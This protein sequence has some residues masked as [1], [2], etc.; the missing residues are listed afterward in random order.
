ME[1]VVAG[2]YQFQ[3]QQRRL[4]QYKTLGPRRLGQG[5]EGR[6]AIRAV[7]PIE[8]LKRHAPL[9]VNHLQRLLCIGL[10]EETTAQNLMPVDSRLPGLVETRDIQAVHIDAH[11]VDVVARPFAVQRLEQHALLHRRQRIQIFHLGEGQ[12]QRIQ[13]ALRQ[14]RQREVR[15]RDTLVGGGAAML[16]QR[17]E[18]HRVVIRQLLH[19]RLR[20]HCLAETPVQLQFA[21]VD[22]AVDFQPV[23]Q[24]CVKALLGTTGVTGRREQAFLFAALETAVKLPQVVERDT[25]S[26]QGTQRLLRLGIAQVTQGT[27]AEA[28]FRYGAQLLLDLLEGARQ[29]IGRRQLHGIEAGKPTDGAG[30]VDLIEQ[31]LTAVA[32]QPDQHRR[33]TRPAHNDT[34]QGRQQ[35]VVDLCSVSTGSV[36]QQA[37]GKPWVQLGRHTQCMAVAQAGLR[38]GAGQTGAA[39]V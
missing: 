38:V 26:R 36:L 25:W 19:G 9:L 39:A 18:L 7:R 32:F 10:P 12:R 14:A 6:R 15:R 2:A 21:G 13:L 27:K 23:A 17:L 35:Q 31:V 20:E 37:T 29:G 16:D 3:A 33:V 11:L 22:L 1:A 34:R 24:R 30:Q 28:F 8:R 4:L 5:V